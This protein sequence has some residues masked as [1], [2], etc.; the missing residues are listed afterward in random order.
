[1]SLKE[2]SGMFPYVTPHNLPPLPF[3]P[4]KVEFQKILTVHNISMS[5]KEYFLKMSTFYDK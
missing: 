4:L 1:M 3:S 5:L 2:Y